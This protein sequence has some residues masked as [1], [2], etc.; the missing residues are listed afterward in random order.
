MAEFRPANSGL[1]IGYHGCH[2]NIAQRVLTDRTQ[3]EP[4]KND[5]DWLGNGIYFWE[6]SESRARQWAVSKY[7]ENGAVVGAVFNLRHCLSLQ[8]EEG[9]QLVENAFENLRNLHERTEIE[10]PKNSGGSDRLLRKLDCSVIELLHEVRADAGQAAFD[11]VRA[12]FSE[13]A[14]IYPGAGFRRDDHVQICIRN[15]DCILG[16]FEPR[17]GSDGPPDS[18]TTFLP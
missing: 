4:S 18:A 3:L 12:F 14:P 6:D 1:V 2:K 13:G 15:Q 17:S 8:R 5:Y 7:G 11:S 10:L 16:L 9:L